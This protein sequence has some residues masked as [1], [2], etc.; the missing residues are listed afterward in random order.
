MNRITQVL[1]LA[2]G[3]IYAWIGVYFLFWPEHGTAAIGVAMLDDTGRTDIMATYGGMMLGMAVMYGWCLWD[4]GRYRAGLWLTL[5]TCAG[6]AFGR[7]TAI[8][9]G[10]RPGAMMWAF[11]VLELSAVALSTALLKRMV[12]EDSQ[13]ESNR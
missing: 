6:L 7:L 10:E 13:S 5:L 3:L 11:L 2:S 12:S 8:S 4:I 1:L 9:G